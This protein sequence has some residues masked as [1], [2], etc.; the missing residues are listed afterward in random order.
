VAAEPSAVR[1]REG[2]VAFIGALIDEYRANPEG[3]ENGDLPRFLASLAAWIDD[4]PGYWTNQGLPEPEQPD[5]SWV[6]LSLRAATQ[7][8]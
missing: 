3:W 5:W 4:S 7:Y 8:E 2:L 1:T 6:A